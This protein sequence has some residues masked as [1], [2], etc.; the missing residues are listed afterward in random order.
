MIGCLC[1]TMAGTVGAIHERALSGRALAEHGSDFLLLA[2]DPKASRAFSST[3][4]RGLALVAFLRP[5][6]PRPRAGQRRL[7]RFDDYVAM[8]IARGRPLTP[9]AWCVKAYRPETHRTAAAIG[10]KRW[11]ARLT[12][13]VSRCARAT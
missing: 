6:L 1:D 4:A 13:P 3:R 11:M 10:L 7:H 12:G 5:D 8:L 2:D 9:H